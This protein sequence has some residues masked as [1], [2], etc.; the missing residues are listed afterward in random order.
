MGERYPQELAP[1]ALHRRTDATQLG[2]V[3]MSA[4]RDTLE[5]IDG[6]QRARDAIEFAL[7]MRERRYNLYVSGEAGTGRTSAVEQ[8]VERAARNR[9]PAPDW[10]YAY[11]F[12]MPQRPMPLRLPPGMGPAF[13]AEMKRF[14]LE[15]KRALR[16]QFSSK[17]YLKSRNGIHGTTEARLI[18]LRDEL[19]ASLVGLGYV[20]VGTLENPTIVPGRAVEVG[21]E[22]TPGAE[23][24]DAPLPPEVY[25]VPKTKEEMG[26]LTHEEREALNA[27]REAALSLAAEAMQQANAIEAERRR[28]LRAIDETVAEAVTQQHM[29]ALAERFGEWPAIKR[30]LD[31]LERDVIQHALTLAAPEEPGEAS[32]HYSLESLTLRY[33][34]N[35]LTSAGD[36]Q[37]APIVYERNPT[38]A[39]LVGHLELPAGRVLVDGVHLLIRPGALHRA[40]GGYLV[41]Q[42][43]DVLRNEGAWEAVRHMLR[44]RSI[45][46]EGTGDGRMYSDEGEIHPTAIQ[47]DVK[48]ILIGDESAYRT[49][50]DADPEFHELFKV[51]ADFANTVPRTA[52][53]E[54]YYARLA[55]KVAHDARNP[56]FD[57]DAVAAL[58]EEGSRWAGDQERLSAQLGNLSD[59]ANEA[60]S[61]AA[62]AGAQ[63][64]T[65]QHVEQAIQTRRFRMSRGVDDFLN[66][67]RAGELVIETQGTAL[68]QAN[69]VTI[70]HA[71]EHVFGRPVR[72]TAQAGPGQQGIHDIH[73]E[74]HLTDADHQ[75]GSHTLYGYLVGKFARGFPL[76]LSATI[77]FEQ[78]NMP[79]KGDSCSAAMLCALLSALSGKPINQSLAITGAIDLRGQLLAIGNASQ[80]VEGF[81]RVCKLHELT[82]A[83]GVVIPVASRHTLMLREEVVEAVRAGRFHVYAVATVDKAMELLTGLS[84]GS[85]DANGEYPP[86]SINGLVRETLRQ[87][88]HQTWGTGSRRGGKGG[89]SL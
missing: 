63:L 32:D 52:E 39:N 82:G 1:E 26:S 85:P 53:A 65:R 46:A 27:N 88:S 75:R 58:I 2:D 86:D 76:A 60:A 33:S 11:N 69:G 80:K 10:C 64:T 16:R 59:L 3:D 21:A 71:G 28:Q 47:A 19:D 14:V 13:V 73:R 4:A 18:A 35:L 50:A 55:S 34:V 30:Y 48:V 84:A 83:Q 51:K 12:E 66:R 49:L 70:I 79:I 42:A 45:A 57:A 23:A 29:R 20:L 89:R 17:S 38:Y 36:A 81:Y 56:Q 54:R 24:G 77:A 67:V 8:A 62:S 78:L 44:F 40:N 9:P 41:L 37:H 25:Y 15:V 5:T 72:I 43:A 6:Q 31:L 68:G 22:A 7:N 74:I 61:F 87:F